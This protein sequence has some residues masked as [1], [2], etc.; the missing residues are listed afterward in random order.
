V[1]AESTAAL[2]SAREEIYGLVRKIALLEGE[3]A[4]VCRAHEVS[5]ETARGLSNTVA[6]AERWQEESE[7][8]RREQ[9]EELTLL[10]TRCSE[11]CL[12]IVGPPQVRNHLSGEMRIA[13]LRH[14]EMAEEFAILQA[15]VS[16]A[17]EFTLGQSP[18]ETFQVEVVDEL[19]TKFLKLEER[20]SQLERPGMRICDFLLG[21]P[22]G[23]ARLVD[24]LDE[25]TGWPGTELATRREA[26]AELEALWD[27]LL[28]QADGSSSQAAS[29]STAAEL[30]EGRVDIG[31]HLVTLPRAESRA[32]AS[33]IRSQCGPGRGSGGCPLDPGASSPGLA[34]TAHPSFGCPRHS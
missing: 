2:A 12:T 3:L 1:E 20:C 31:R 10:Q 4:E 13:A 11:L 5:E 22:F 16:S 30:L 6:N 15:V 9:L 18:D 29:L 17:V 28:D 8:G 34:S 32:R 24:H 25:A 23:R 33:W 7:R 26:N 27:L 19:V 14:T 21:L